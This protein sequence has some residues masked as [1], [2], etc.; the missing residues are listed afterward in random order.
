[1]KP[2]PIKLYTGNILGRKKTIKLMFTFYLYL[3]FIQT[4]KSEIAVK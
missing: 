2:P 4:Q 1:M 3:A